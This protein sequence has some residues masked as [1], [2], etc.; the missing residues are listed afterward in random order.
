[1]AT[2]IQ[3]S[4]R[5]KKRLLKHKASPR[6]TYEEVIERALEALEEDD[7][8]FSAEFKKKLRQGRRDVAA[9]RTYTTERL[10]RELGL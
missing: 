4:E 9:G 7:L 3:V 8:E 6:Q 10:R 1:M 2:T 5:L